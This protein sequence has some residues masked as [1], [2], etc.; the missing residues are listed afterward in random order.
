MIWNKKKWVVC[1]F[2]EGLGGGG[3]GYKRW[4]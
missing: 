3:F 4:C 2:G 1:G